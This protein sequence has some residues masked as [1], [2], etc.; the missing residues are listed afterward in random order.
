MQPLKKVDFA[1]QRC[2][3]PTK[4]EPRRRAPKFCSRECRLLNRSEPH[5]TK[6]CGRC[7]KE[8]G[9]GM[10]LSHFE[11]AVYCSHACANKGKP[12]NPKTTRYRQV[13]TKDGRRIGEHRDVIE[14]ALGV[15]LHR[16]QHVH[17]K[18]EVK[19]DNRH[20]NLEVMPKS[21]HARKHRMEQIA[22]G[23]M[24]GRGKKW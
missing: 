23:Q 9:S 7:G 4:R 12:I 21:D 3:I 13:E 11:K 18:N 6:F 8:F 19:T 5:G 15:R 17:H 2:G 14:K 22:K 1:C 10:D 24:L 16:N 20:D